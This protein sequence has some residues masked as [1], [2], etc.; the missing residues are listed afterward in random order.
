LDL[1]QRGG[2]DLNTSNQQ[3]L[4]KIKSNDKAIIKKQEI[5]EKKCHFEIWIGKAIFLLDKYMD[6]LNSLD[7]E[8]DP[9][10]RGIKIQDLECYFMTSICLFLRCFMDCN[11]SH[12][13][14]IGG[15]TKDRDL[16]YC[17]HSL[18]ELRD[19]EYVHWKGLRSKIDIK[20]NFNIYSIESKLTPCDPLFQLGAVQHRFKQQFSYQY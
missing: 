18:K 6:T 10:Q 2:K 1:S 4:V 16:H 9:T 17:Y 19:D 14:K 12:H 7:L 3:F 15:V 20:C 13:L 5:I 11:R 8:Q